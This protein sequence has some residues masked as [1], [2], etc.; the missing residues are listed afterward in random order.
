MIISYNILL[1]DLLVIM[2]SCACK[3]VFP[4][5]SS[6]INKRSFGRACKKACD[7]R[8]C[9]L[10]TRSAAESFA[11][12]ANPAFADK[13]QLVNESAEDKGWL[14]PCTFSFDSVRNRICKLIIKHDP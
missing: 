8:E 4:T 14:V 3:D 13:P 9:T 11:L 7:L 1:F 5:P 12:E 10:G 2:L 6:S